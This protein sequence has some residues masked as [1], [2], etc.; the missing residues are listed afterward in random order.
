[1]SEA[2]PPDQGPTPAHG[3]RPA[4]KVRPLRVLSGWGVFFLIVGLW[5]AQNAL[6]CGGGSDLV[7]RPAPAFQSAIAAGEGAAAGDRVSLEGLRGRP[8]LLDFWA[9][10][11]APCRASVPVLSRLAQRHRDA[12]LVVLG[13]NIEGDRPR[14]HVERAHEA[15]GAAFPT[16]HDDTWQ[17]QQAY[18]V[19]SIPTMVLIDRRGVVRWIDAGLPSEDAL[20]ARILEI[21]AESP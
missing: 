15:L 21:L 13:V 9:S 18:G 12:G 10:W 1:M 8:V 4:R 5:A 3:P 14:A 16:L 7:A 19:R 6:Q 11:C 2:F 17:I 20:D